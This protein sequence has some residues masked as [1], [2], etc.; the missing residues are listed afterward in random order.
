MLDN[1]QESAGRRSSFNSVNGS[2]RNALT[3][4]S[5][6]RKSHGEARVSG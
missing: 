1:A 5:V 2:I 4:S 3:A 6:C